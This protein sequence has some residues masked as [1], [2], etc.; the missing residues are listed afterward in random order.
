MA[1]R[2]RLPLLPETPRWGRAQS[3]DPSDPVHVQVVTQHAFVTWERMAVFGGSGG[4][5]SGR[6]PGGRVHSRGLVRPTSATYTKDTHTRARRTPSPR[7]TCLNPPC[8]RASPLREPRAPLP[9][10]P[11]LHGAAL[12][13]SSRAGLQ[14][15]AGEA[16]QSTCT[17]QPRPARR[18]GGRYGGGRCFPGGGARCPRSSPGLQRR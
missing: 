7:H 16:A 1:Q 14:E 2:E 18:A 15:R 6:H 8:F 10:L 4:R 9:E 11:P 5:P 13:P 12:P 3:S 17:S